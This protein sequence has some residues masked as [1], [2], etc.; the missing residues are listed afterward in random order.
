M[1]HEPSEPP[2]D[3][4]RAGVAPEGPIQVMVKEESILGAILEYLDFGSFFAVNEQ[5]VMRC[6]TR[7]GCRLRPTAQVLI[8]AQPFY[9]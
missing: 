2:V 3:E 7:S 9:A 1:D 6:N 4:G 8:F 5:E